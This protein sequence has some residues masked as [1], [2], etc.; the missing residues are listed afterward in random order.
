MENT[1]WHGRGKHQ[2]E[3]DRLILLMPDSGQCDTVAGELIR[4]AT[5][6]AYDLYNNGMGNNTSGAV[7][8]LRA[9]GAITEQT[10]S[11]IY[12]YTRGRL[13]DGHYE[14]DALQV[15]V[16]HMMDST[17]EMVL[18]NPQLETQPN[19]EDMFEYED[20]EQHWCE[21]CGDETDR[22]DTVCRQCEES[23]YEEEEAEEEE[24]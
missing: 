15:A 24:Y 2:A 3:Y 18:A 13:Y 6:L 10:H 16:E 23:Y 1:Y 17:V 19:S 9:K 12:A 7:N 20:P 21:E 8:F 4:S 5:R 11:T 22:W 14:G